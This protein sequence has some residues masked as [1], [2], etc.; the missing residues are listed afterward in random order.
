VRELDFYE[1]VSA[2]KQLLLSSGIETFS[3]LVQE[4]ENG[5]VRV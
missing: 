3:Q 4:D 2:C 5:M 1:T